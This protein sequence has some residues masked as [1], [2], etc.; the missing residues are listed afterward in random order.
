MHAIAQSP[1][2]TYA[3]LGQTFKAN[4]Y[5]VYAKMRQEDPVCC[6]TDFNDETIYCV[7]PYADVKK[8]LLEHKRFVKDMRNA[9]T[10]EEVAARPGWKVI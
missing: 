4:A 8:V 7:T 5:A 9:L 2:Q 6:Q 1:A 10:P 3:L